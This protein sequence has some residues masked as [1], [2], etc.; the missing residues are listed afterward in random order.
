MS[1]IE[2]EVEE[3]IGGIER[4]TTLRHEAVDYAVRCMLG[5]I[6]DHVESEAEKK[7]IKQGQVSG[8]HY[9]ALRETRQRLKLP[10]RKL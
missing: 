3:F 6:F 4:I 7:T 10:E 2:K 9:A 8:M 5:K 1:D